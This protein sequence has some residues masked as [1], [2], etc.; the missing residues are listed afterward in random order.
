MPAA[1]RPLHITNLQL[2]DL[3]IVELAKCIFDEVFK[4][5]FLHLKPEFY[6]CSAYAVL[7]VVKVFE[8]VAPIVSPLKPSSLFLLYL[9]T[10]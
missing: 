5:C 4:P 9:S 2:F 7:F 1:Q 3:A 6:P 10:P 8:T